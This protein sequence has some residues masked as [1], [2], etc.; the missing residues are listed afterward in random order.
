MAMV[1]SLGTRRKTI[2]IIVFSVYYFLF[3]ISCLFL[4]LVTSSIT[5]T[6]TETFFFGTK[7]TGLGSRKKTIISSSNPPSSLLKS[8]VSNKKNWYSIDS[9]KVLQ[10]SLDYSQLWA[11]LLFNNNDPVRPVAIVLFQNLTQESDHTSFQ[12][13]N[14][15][16]N[17]WGCVSLSAHKDKNTL[18]IQQIPNW[19][20]PTTVAG[21]G[22]DID[23]YLLPIEGIYGV[24]LLPSGPCLAVILES[25]AVYNSPTPMSMASHASPSLIPPF[26][27]IRRVIRI[28]II[29]IPFQ[30]NEENVTEGDPDYFHF[31]SLKRQQRKEEI[32]QINLLRKAL[33]SH[34]LYY[35]PPRRVPKGIDSYRIGDVTH[36]V[37]RSLVSSIL[38]TGSSN[39]CLITTPP[40]TLGDY[41]QMSKLLPPDSRFFWNQELIRPLLYSSTTQH[42]HPAKSCN[43]TLTS[44]HTKASVSVKNSLSDVVININSTITVNTTAMF[45]HDNNNT[46]TNLS[47]TASSR[48]IFIETSTIAPYSAQQLLQRWIIP[49]TSAFVG[50]TRNIPLTKPSVIGPCSVNKTV[51][52]ND[53]KK[54]VGHYYDEILI[55][56]RS[57]FRAGTR[58][59]RRGADNTGSVANFAETEQ[60]I[61]IKEVG[62]NKLDDT[63]TLKEVYSFVQTRGSIPLIWSSPANVREYAPRVQIATN[64]LDQAR[65]LRAHLLE[66]IWL[67]TP[68]L[69]PNTKLRSSISNHQNLRRHPTAS[70]AKYIYNFKE[71]RTK[72][73]EKLIFVN[74]VD[75]KKDQGRL[76][77]A[78]DSVLQA[79]LDVHG[80]E[81]REQMSEISS[82]ADIA[83]E[84][85]DPFTFDHILVE[86]YTT[87]PTIPRGSV[88]HIWYDFHAEC[89]G[90]KWNRLKALLDVLSPDL[91]SHRYFS[92][93]PFTDNN[94]SLV[95]WNIASV[96]TGIVRTNCMDCLDRT[97]VV[98]TMFGRYV[99]FRQLQNRD[100]APTDSK[101]A[102][103]DPKRNAVGKRK[104]PLEWVVAF[105]SNTLQLPFLEGERAH[106]ILWADN[107][108]AISR[109]YAGTPALKGDYT[110][111]GRRTKRGALDDG[112]NSLTRYYIN[113]FSDADRQ[114]GIDLMTGTIPF[115]NTEDSA[116]GGAV[117]IALLRA[118][119]YLNDDAEL[120]NSTSSSKSTKILHAQLNLRRLLFGD[121]LDYL[122]E[123]RT[124]SPFASNEGNRIA[125]L[126]QWASS[127][128][129][130]WITL[131][132]KKGL[133]TFHS[134]KRMSNAKEIVQTNK[135]F[136]PNKW[137]LVT[138][139]MLDLINSYFPELI[140]PFASVLCIA[141]LFT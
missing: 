28:D 11:T 85:L 134:R 106:R 2:R 71:V 104:I 38:H 79:I 128:L 48:K 7:T 95:S 1:V 115:S 13:G 97:N 31:F 88:S 27:E 22:G 99:L 84:Y 103:L 9:Q 30:A 34:S 6:N 53:T 42:Y 114:E 136:R 24:Y 39:S 121:Y 40:T 83:K 80:E 133:L 100:A 59:T 44:N 5:S 81:H 54:G 123:V 137:A 112:V 57:R 52:T 35:I 126:E 17:I 90:G 120:E 140:T 117:K 101:S 29:P 74:L 32:R 63:G 55:S 138:M 51:G 25:E 60:I 111:T 43:E 50:I 132:R 92:A 56:R 77:K 124:A 45:E 119:N 65:A 94:M 139:V 108:D 62:N 33:R 93:S 129:P 96:Q 89:K 87:T 16:E 130:W 109:L 23:D 86:N 76:G 19:T 75:K 41:N 107:A 20:L 135:K 82:S 105:K 67:Y 14:L 15:K 69:L 18:L 10:K 58:F 68:L 46:Y 21:G 102:S 78:F 61:L 141:F 72:I 127:K 37:Q 91:D 70:D 4:C 12:T 116:F 122:H 110:R 3:L 49:C 8:W 66:Q 98:Q 118:K 125:S 113:N 47:S 36:T 64:P 131:N 26:L 73:P